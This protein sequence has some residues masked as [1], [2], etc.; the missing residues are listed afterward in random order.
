MIKKQIAIQKLELRKDYEFVEAQVE[1]LKDGLNIFNEEE[2][3]ESEELRKALLVLDP[4][5]RLEL[6]SD[7]LITNDGP[8]PVAL[9]ERFEREDDD[10][11]PQVNFTTTA[12]LVG[13]GDGQVTVKVELS[14]VSTASVTVGYLVTGTAEPQS[15]HDLS[16]QGTIKIQPGNLIQHENDIAWRINAAVDFLFGKP[17]SFVSKSPNSQKRA[18]IEAIL[19]TAFMANGGIGFFQDMAVLGSVYGFVDCLVR[20]GDVVLIKGSNSLKLWEL[21]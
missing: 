20:P 2:N 5:D 19:K 12:A 18:Q 7:F 6:F 4:K 15:D 13:E 9:L 17:I 8:I 1:L 11:I 21:I 16:R 14:H 3:K 10:G